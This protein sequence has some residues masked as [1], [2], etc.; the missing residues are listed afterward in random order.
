MNGKVGLKTL[1]DTYS[2]IEL[3]TTLSDFLSID[4]NT[5]DGGDLRLYGFIDATGNNQAAP[6]FFRCAW[7]AEYFPLFLKTDKEPCFPRSPLLVIPEAR[8]SDYLRTSGCRAD[9]DIT[10]FLS[11]LNLKQQVPFWQSLIYATSPFGERILHRFWDGFV[12][13]NYLNVL[14][15]S[16]LKQLFAPVHTLFAPAEKHWLSKDLSQCPA[17]IPTNNHDAWWQIRSHHLTAF[18]RQFDQVQESDIQDQLWRQYPLQMGH[19]YPPLIPQII[20][21]GIKQAKDLGVRKEAN[22]VRFI[23][24]QLKELP[25][26]WRQ[27]LWLPIWSQKNTDIEFERRLMQVQQ[28]QGGELT[29]GTAKG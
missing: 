8:H 24:L 28:S 3:A 17:S 25:T 20:Q 16:E 10:W 11:Q 14:S 19:V 18:G 13:K 23:Y 6:D 4:K 1:K 29:E 22:M 9:G 2:E 5:S 21:S 27:P 15:D 7:D 12:I 26:F